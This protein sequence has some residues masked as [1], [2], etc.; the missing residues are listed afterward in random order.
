[1]RKAIKELEDE[2]QKVNMFIEV[3]DARIPV[4]SHNPELL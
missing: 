3:R 4:T 1:M 2:I